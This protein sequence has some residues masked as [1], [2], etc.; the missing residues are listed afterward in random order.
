VVTYPLANIT[1]AMQWPAGAQPG[2][3]AELHVAGRVVAQVGEGAETRLLFAP[4][5]D[6]DQLFVVDLDLVVADAIDGRVEARLLQPSPFVPHVG[7]WPGIGA[8]VFLGK[9]IGSDGAAEPM[10]SLFGSRP[11]GPFGPGDAT[12]VL[13]SGSPAAAP[14]DPR[15]AP[16]SAVGRLD[17]VATEAVLRPEVSA[18]RLEIG[19][20]GAILDNGRDTLVTPGPQF[21]VLVDAPT[22]SRVMTIASPG[23]DLDPSNGVTTAAGTTAIPVHLP[24]GAATLTVLVLTP[25][26]AAYHGT[27]QVEQRTGPPPLTLEAPLLPLSGSVRVTGITEPGSTAT[28]NGAAV[29]VD[30]EGRFESVVSAT[31]TPTSYLVE[32]VDRVGNAA[33]E[34]LSVVGWVDYR[35]LPWIPIISVLTLAAGIVLWLR[36]PRPRAWSRKGTEDDAVLE[37][38]DS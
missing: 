38:I 7:P 15:L 6:P 11:I 5:D 24:S 1:D 31:L 37:E 27:W 2:R 29:T 3:I 20:R 4:S 33:T 22:G 19:L 8:H 32:V 28:V 35:R 26:G 21:D 36:V 14:P 23:E 30:A 25:A 13:L 12:T 34:R 10:A 17:L 9:R 16:G 18:G